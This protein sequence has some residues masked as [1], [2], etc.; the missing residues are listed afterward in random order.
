MPDASP[1]KW[2]LAH[3]TWF[4]ET[5]VLAH[6]GPATARSSRRSDVLFNSYYQASGRCIRAPQRGLLSRPTL[7]RCSAT[8]QQVDERIERALA[9]GDLDERC[10][11]AHRARPAPRAAAPGADPH[12]HQA[13]AVVQPAA[14]GVSRATCASPTAPAAPLRWIARDE[15]LGRGRCAARGPRPTASPSTTRRRGTACWCRRFALASR[16]VTNGEYLAFID[17][18]GYRARAVAAD[19]WA[20][21]CSAERL[22]APLYWAR[23]TR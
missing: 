1:A 4:F 5:F 2:H 13:R 15:Q 22:D 21:A 20:L 16:P 10:A 9:A 11:A 17:D 23:R 6:A 19:G 18:G 3:T 14:P 12:R 8:A 7:R